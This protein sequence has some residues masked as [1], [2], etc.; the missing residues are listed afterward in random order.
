MPQANSTTSRP[1]VTSPRASETTLPC[2]AVISSASSCLCWFTSSRNAN[3][4]WVRLVS[5]EFRQEANAAAA[6]AT[7]WSTS[8]TEASGTS[9]RTVPSAGS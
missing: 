7:A 3:S 2:S 9:V 4:T 1:R 8:S 5:D 6:E